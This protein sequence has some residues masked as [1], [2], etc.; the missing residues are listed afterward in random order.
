[1][2]VTEKTKGTLENQQTAMKN[3]KQELSSTQLR[4]KAEITQRS[5]MATT[6]LQWTAAVSEAKVNIYLA[7]L[8]WGHIQDI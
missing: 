3:I 7:K 5:T 8:V 1:M 2:H 6:H 4:L